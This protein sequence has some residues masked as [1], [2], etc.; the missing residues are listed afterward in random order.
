M[1]W[2]TIQSLFSGTNLLEI[3]DLL[4][5]KFPLLNDIHWEE[6]NDGLGYKVAGGVNGDVSVDTIGK[7]TVTA[8][9]G[10]INSLVAT[11]YESKA[12]AKL[13][14]SV[15]GSNP[16]E[17][18]TRFANIKI[19]SVFR[20]GIAAMLG[21]KYSGT[22]WTVNKIGFNSEY[23]DGEK[24][25]CTEIDATGT[26][27]IYG[28]TDAWIIKWDADGAMCAFPFINGTPMISLSSVYPTLDNGQSVYAQ[29]IG[30]YFAP[31][32]V[33]PTS[34]VKIK[35]LNHPLTG[36]GG[37]YI[38][39]DLLLEAF[40][41]LDEP[42]GANVSIVVAKSQLTQF[43]KTLNNKT[44]LLTTVSQQ[45]NVGLYDK[46][47]QYNGGTFRQIIDIYHSNTES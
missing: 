19:A 6:S 24:I 26:A 34:I 32:A 38:T 17:K 13:P 7:A 11:M 33:R 8:S 36:N 42:D 5:K 30:W 10:T 22:A 1:E 46:V 40:G 9:T 44:N 35:N 25:Y 21:Y 47:V 3:H 31:C 39:E 45:T 15:A 43:L 16:A 2:S 41:V 12:I 20:F 14:F 23:D 29:D 28:L 18:M 4:G 27:N 37:K